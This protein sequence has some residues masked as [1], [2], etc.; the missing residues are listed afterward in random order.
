[1]N[2]RPPARGRSIEMEYH[3]IL[4]LKKEPFSTSPDPAFF[5]QSRQHVLCLQKLELAVRLRRGMSVVIG[6]VGTGKTTLCRKLIRTLAS[7]S[8]VE[9]FLILDPSFKN[10][11]ECLSAVA[12]TLGAVKGD[13]VVTSERRLKE[14]VKK[15]LFKKGVEEG[16]TVVLI[17]DEGQKMPAFFMEILRE[18]LNYETNDAKLLQIVIFAQNEFESSLKTHPNFADRVAFWYALKPMGFLD[19]VR[20]V[21]FRLRLAG[22]EG[23]ESA[24][25]FTLP[26]LWRVYRSSGGYPRK[27]IHICHQSLLTMIVQAR[28]KAGWS[29]VRAAERLAN[30]GRRSRRGI[31]AG[32]VLAVIVLG[33]L[34]TDWLPRSVGMIGRR[35]WR[36]STTEAPSLVVDDAVR[37]EVVPKS[38]RGE[39]RSLLRAMPPEWLGEIQ[40]AQDETL[41]E[42]V[43]RV[44]GSSAPPLIERVIA[45]NPELS[46]PHRIAV[47]QSI[48]FPMIRFR[49]TGVTDE[50]YY[51]EAGREATL[52]TAY[53]YVRLRLPL[54]SEPLRIIPL[55]TPETGL[56]FAV[57]LKE[58]HSDLK[59]A[60]KRLDEI[61]P[62]FPMPLKIRASWEMGGLHSWLSEE[63][64]PAGD[65]KWSE[66]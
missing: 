24:G 16:K 2:R 27:I 21:R 65:R 22:H 55:W 23:D 51:I 20:M 45:A 52:G 6:E 61:A 3:R 62:A 18:L 14:H 31:F 38:T 47:G 17:V 11:A 58:T 60:R 64:I 57:V 40:V 34:S 36:V 48:R 49:Q 33:G 30:A 19:V 35:Q 13:N 12:N 28:T 26:A 15:H 63:K 54:L 66:Y 1:M 46:N 25:L 50:R 42:I 59:S 41:G 44:Y 5:F 4:N 43:N 8:N 9:T 29:Q 10:A 39:R 56:S 32:G 7:E 53:E 37:D